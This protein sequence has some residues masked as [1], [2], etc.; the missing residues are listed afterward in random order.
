[1]VVGGTFASGTSSCMANA[2]VDW[3]WRL[4]SYRTII[5]DRRIGTKAREAAAMALSVE[6]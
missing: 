2:L 6:E 4:H 3:G 1:V 5:A